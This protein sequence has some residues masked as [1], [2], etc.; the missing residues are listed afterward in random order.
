MCLLVHA[1]IQ[2]PAAGLAFSQLIK[3]SHR[4]ESDVFIWQ[5]MFLRIFIWSSWILY[6][7]CLVFTKHD[8]YGLGIWSEQWVSQW[9]I[10]AY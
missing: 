10:L 8:T 1:Q 4:K 3:D 7:E 2:I 5:G 6:Q 9:M